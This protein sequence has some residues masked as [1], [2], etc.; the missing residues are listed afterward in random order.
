[1]FLLLSIIS[2][3]YKKKKETAPL[4][5]TLGIFLS[6]E[7]IKVTVWNRKEMEESYSIYEVFL[8]AGIAINY[9]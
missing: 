7:D 5:Y 4:I 9:P 6:C 1:M 8:F 2:E 3:D